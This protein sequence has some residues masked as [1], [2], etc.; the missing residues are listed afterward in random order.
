[1]LFFSLVVLIGTGWSYMRPFIDDRTRKVLMVVV[2]LQV[3]GRG[4]A[5]GG[6]G[7]MAML[8]MVSENSSSLIACLRVL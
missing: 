6:E 3:R 1:M 8:E 2:P 4:G 5:G 7:C